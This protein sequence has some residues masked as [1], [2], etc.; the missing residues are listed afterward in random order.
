MRIAVREA[1]PT[2]ATL[3]TRTFDSV[4]SVRVMTGAALAHAGRALERRERRH[5]ADAQ[6]AV[7]RRVDAGVARLDAR[8][9]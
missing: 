2:V 5:R 4:R 1:P 6:L 9:G 7:R 3:R 8:A